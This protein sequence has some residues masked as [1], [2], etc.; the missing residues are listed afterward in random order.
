MKI[1]ITPG[2]L[3]LLIALL[4][5]AKGAAMG[6]L[7]AALLHECGHL[8]AARLLGIRLR[9]LELDLAGAKLYPAR[10][11]RSYRDEGILAAAGPL[12][13]LAGALLSPFPLPF[14][15]V[16]RLACLSQALFN[17]LPIDGFDGG[18]ILFSVLA[19]LLDAERARRAL[20][21]C[22]YLCLLLLFALS[23]CLLLRYG[24]SMAL[25]VLSASIF[26][27]QFLPQ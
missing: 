7:F 20:A 22:T 16:F 23:A 6:I 26:A 13:S 11:I 14:F 1:R 21:L 3:L 2:A 10:A 15:H 25:A 24:E 19:R 4:F 12:A 17:L 8:L 5:D 9:L 18:R 27:R